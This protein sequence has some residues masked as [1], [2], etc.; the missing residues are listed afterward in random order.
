M[1]SLSPVLQQR[2]FDTNGLPLAG[3]KVYTYAAG[4]AGATPK[5]TYR[6][7]SLTDPNANPII[8]DASGG[9]DLWLDS[10]GYLLVVKDAAGSLVDTFDN[11]GGN[12]LSGTSLLFTALSGLAIDAG[13]TSVITVGYRTLGKGAATYVYDAAVNGAFVIAH[14]GWS[15]LAADGRGFRLSPEQRLWIECFGAYGDATNITLGT[16]DYPAFV[17]A[18]NFMEYFRYAPSGNTDYKPVPEV[19]LSNKGYR[20]SQTLIL[21]R[22]AYRFIGSGNNTNGYGGSFIFVDSGQ[23][24]IVIQC[25]DNIGTGLTGTFLHHNYGT[26]PR[27]AQN[28]HLADF[29]LQ[30]KGGT[31]G[32]DS[33]NGVLVHTNCT[34]ERIHAFDFGGN[35]IAVVADVA[36]GTN[37]N[38]VT[39]DSCGGSRNGLNGYYDQGGDVNAG[40]VLSFQAFSNRQFG[41]YAGNFLGQYYLW[42]QCDGNGIGS[43]PAWA[44]GIGSS[45]TNY[46]GRKY[47]VRP[48]AHVLASTTTP[49]TNANVWVDMGAGATGLGGNWVSG[50]TFASGGG[51]YA[52]GVNFAQNNNSRNVFAGYCEQNQF[53]GW[54]DSNTSACLPG[55]S[56]WGNS[57]PNLAAAFGRLVSPAIGSYTGGLTALHQIHAYLGGAA[58]PTDNVFLNLGNS[59]DGSTPWTF[60]VDDNNDIFQ[61]YAGAASSESFRM[62][63]PGSTVGITFLRGCAIQN[64][65]QF[66]NSAVPSSGTYVRG[67]VIWNYLPSAGGT[68]G[69]VCTTG[70][71]AGSTAVFKAMANIAA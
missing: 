51:F 10:G 16:D 47:Y 68:P 48:G 2:F 5:T 25:W 36:G 37:A 58:G 24:G 52:G 11:V 27:G 57:G 15:F 71:V 7:N 9:C 28:T 32:D 69:W 41:I 3:G 63:A 4:S 18:K 55:F 42:F 39:I 30:S 22:A 54:T 17:A 40:R 64:S 62:L 26:D 12:S 50:Q 53:N 33:Q 29:S 66:S 49:G 61:K 21:D 8:L 13:I 31:V 65:Y 67:S 44:A 6:S 70:G 45:W 60:H 19:R 46:G 14:P 20:L 1:V 23:A 34:L 59:T 38:G 35:G 56:S 43:G